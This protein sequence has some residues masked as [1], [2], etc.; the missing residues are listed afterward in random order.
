LHRL[1]FSV[2]VPC[3]RRPISIYDTHKLI[4]LSRPDPLVRRDVKSLVQSHLDKS[5]IRLFQWWFGGALMVPVLP[6]PTP[7]PSTKDQPPPTPCIIPGCPRTAEPDGKYCREHAQ[8]GTRKRTPK[9]P[10]ARG[11]G[12]RVSRARRRV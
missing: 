5:T 2:R 11:T 9:T 7:S 12:P 10:Y 8:H 1:P 6:T 3:P 4:R